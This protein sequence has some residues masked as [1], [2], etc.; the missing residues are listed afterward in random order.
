MSNYYA[1]DVSFYLSF[2]YWMP[3]EVGSASGQAHRL[4]SL[5]VHSLQVPLST[6]ILMKIYHIFGAIGPNSRIARV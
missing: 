2:K 1:H 4:L 5:I 3:A 6:L